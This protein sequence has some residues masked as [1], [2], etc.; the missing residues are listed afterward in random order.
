M[1]TRNAAV[2]PPRERGF[3]LVELS[4]VIALASIL[5]SVAI[6]A[7]LVLQEQAQGAAVHAALRNVRMELM[8]STAGGGEPFRPSADLVDVL[9][10]DGDPQISLGLAGD[11]DRWC[12]WAKHSALEDTWALGQSG[13]AVE[14]GGCSPRGEVIPPA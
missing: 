9:T 2:A 8:I 14:G 4:V 6:P 3:T 11:A 1:P 10:S 13:A 12:L 5:A 7:C